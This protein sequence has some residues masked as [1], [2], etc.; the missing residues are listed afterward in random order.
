MAT[1]PGAGGLP[2]NTRGT[3]TNPAPEQRPTPSTP[4][5]GTQRNMAIKGRSPLHGGGKGSSK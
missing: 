4:G 2:I 1:K 5:S 3:H